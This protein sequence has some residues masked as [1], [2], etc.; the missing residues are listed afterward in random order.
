VE[1]NNE[2][3]DM[4]NLMDAVKKFELRNPLANEETVSVAIG[5][6]TQRGMEAGVEF[7]SINS[8]DVRVEKALNCK[9]LPLAIKLESDVKAISAFMGVLDNLEKSLVKVKSFNIRRKGDDPSRL[10]TDLSVDMYFSGEE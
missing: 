5:E 6:L 7:S 10:E 3:N 9:C 2:I 1:L 8:G 4:R